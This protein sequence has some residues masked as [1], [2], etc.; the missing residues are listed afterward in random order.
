MAN[1]GRVAI[2]PKGDWNAEVEYKRLD[3]VA[4]NNTLYIAKKAVPAGTVTTNTEYWMKCVVGGGGAV[5]TTEDAGIVKP[6]GDT[7]T[8]DEDGTIHGAAVN[9]ATTE[10]AGIVKAGD[11]I[12]VDAAGEMSLKTDFT[13]QADLAELV[14]T[15]DRKTFFG[16][17]A[18]AV[19]ALITHINSKDN[20]HNVT[21]ANVG[22]GNCDNTADSAKSVKYAATAGTLD[23][24]TDFKNSTPVQAGESTNDRGFFLGFNGGA[25]VVYCVPRNDMRVGYATNATNATN[26]DTVDGKHFSDI[27]SDAQARANARLA[28]SG[29]TM[30]GN[31]DLNNNLI[32]NIRIL[33]AAS[34]NP[35]YLQS[36]NSVQITNIAA[37]ANMD[38]RCATLH[39]TGLAAD[40]YRDAKE[41]IAGVA[42]ET[43]RKILDVPV[44]SFDYRPGFGGDKK[45]VI[46]MIVDEVQDIIPEAVVIP[47]DW[48]ESNFNELLGDAGNESVPGVDYTT[49]I[50]YLIALAQLQ[51][52]EIEKLKQSLSALEK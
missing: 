48:D 21:K 8:V 50:P 44:R 18:K 1:A 38:L 22:L 13:A 11:D 36:E 45:N 47:D 32:N 4:Y 43:V 40:S 49:F 39:Y 28:L 23:G 34:S 27:Q 31:I 33:R 51:Q 3:A 10:E 2:V 52:K 30:G 7:I 5:A 14:G 46:G 17:I 15:E 16:K 24:F 41:N 35:L 37:N 26:A 9:V 42:D 25:A 6:D 12:N 20:P 19:S 29:G